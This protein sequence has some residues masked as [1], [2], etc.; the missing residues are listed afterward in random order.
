MMD[1]GIS[2]DRSQL[3]ASLSFCACAMAL[4]NKNSLDHPGLNFFSG[5]PQIQGAGEN[6]LDL[7]APPA[8][9]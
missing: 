1:V 2:R 4:D 9:I 3:A 6:D 7:P 5:C 8:Y